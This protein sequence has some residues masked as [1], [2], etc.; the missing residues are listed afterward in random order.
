[1]TRENDDKID[2]LEAALF[3]EGNPVDMPVQ[4]LFVP[5]MYIR[6]I[7]MPKGEEGEENIVTSAIHKTEHPFFVMA[8]KVAVFSDNDGEQIIEAPYFGVTKP[9][10]RRV[11][12]IIEDTVWITCHPTEVQPVD[13]T[14]EGI[15]EAVLKVKEQI[16]EPHINK[17]LGSEIFRNKLSIEKETTELIH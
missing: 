9:G 1:M 15:Q 11:L 16:I 3:N 6:T 2:Q 4:D 7:Y 13:D 8:G 5:G 17:L 12:R 14:E 10:T